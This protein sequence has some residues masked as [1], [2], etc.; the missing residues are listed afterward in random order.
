[1]TFSALIIISPPLVSISR[2]S[3]QSPASHLTSLKS[4]LILSSHL[5]LG[6]PKGF[7]PQVFPLKFSKTLYAFLDFSIRATCPAHLSS[8][9]LRFLI[10]LCEEYN[11]CSSALCN[12][13][14]SPV[15]SYLLAPNIFLSTLFSN[16]FNLYSSLNVRD[17]V[18]QP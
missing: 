3:I 9:D 16:T 4:I 14:Y 15:V 1:M 13:L 8:F 17:Q 12:F 2:K 10:I 11:A 6:L 18:S 5:C 7:F